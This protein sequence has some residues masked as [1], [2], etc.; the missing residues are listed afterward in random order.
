VSDEQPGERLIAEIQ[1]LVEQ[2][3]ARVGVRAALRFE[4]DSLVLRRG[5]HETRAEIRGTLA[6]WESLPDDLRER[7]AR[8]IA[9]LL[10]TENR[11]PAEQPIAPP[12]Q[13]RGLRWFSVFAPL[14]VVA[15]TAIAIAV[16]YHFLAPQGGGPSLF[17]TK[18]TSSAS[19]AVGAAAPDPDRERQLLAGT[20][21][22]QTRARVARGANIGPADSEGWVVELVLLRRGA[23]VDLSLA[24]GLSRFITRKPGAKTGTLSWPPATHLVAV[25]R[26]DAEVALDANAAPSGSQVSGLSFVF[27]GPYVVPYFTEEQRGDYFKLADALADELGATDGALFAHCASSESHHI[28]SWFLG[29]TPGRAVSSLVY[30]MA[31][32]SEVPVLSSNALGVVSGPPLRGHAFD[33]ISSAASGM[34]RSA[35]ATL[36]GRELGMVSGRPDHATRLTFP[37]RD[38]NRAARASVL[39]ARA[40]DLANSG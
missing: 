24:P 31:S 7:R 11:A 25:Q 8:Q 23:P 33:V 30:F 4:V 15:L 38:A 21:C 26:F 9:A 29:S 17:G 32:F 3:L 6:Q 20:A 22:D 34:D 5:G 16:A 2:E 27:S 28:G 39:A 12:R 35:A 10:A 36:I 18:P 40:L 13:V 19:G 37:F 14:S 1:A